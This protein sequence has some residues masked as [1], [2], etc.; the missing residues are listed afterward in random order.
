MKIAVTGGSGFIGRE[1]VKNLLA[2]GQHVRVLT[3]QTSLNLEELPGAKLVHGDLCDDALDFTG[4]LKDCEAIIHCAGNLTNTSS[5]PALH[6]DATRRLIEAAEEFGVSRWVQMSSCGAYGR[7][8]SGLVSPDDEELPIGVY[9]ETKTE[10]DR[11]VRNAA[12]RGIIRAVL[13]RPAN[14]VGKDMK[15]QSFFSLCR[16][17]D[18]G[19]Y[20]SIGSLIAMTNYVPVENVAAAASRLIYHV[21]DTP[22]KY[23]SAMPTPLKTVIGAIAEG[24]GV[25]EPARNIPYCMAWVVGQTAGRF[26]GFPLTTG[27]VEALTGQAIYDSSTLDQIVGDPPVTDMVTYLRD[28]AAGWKA[29]Q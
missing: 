13:L 11:I 28:L 23:I 4:F 22:Q 25:E 7:R 8:L 17:I 1:V 5:M 12:D 10:A 16:A 14:V 3:R 29:R 2:N 20:F 18:S 19:Q 6:V 27:R 21:S 9:E 24:V 15:N 26:P